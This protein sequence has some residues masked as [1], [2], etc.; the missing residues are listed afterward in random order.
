MT[1][2]IKFSSLSVCPFPSKFLLFQHTKKSQ[3][4]KN[5]TK[6]EIALYCPV[7]NAVSDQKI[8]KGDYVHLNS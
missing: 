1:T 4:M 2:S 8:A 5:L 3:R 7:F 6:I